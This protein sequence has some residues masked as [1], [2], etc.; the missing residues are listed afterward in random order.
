MT[1]TTSFILVPFILAFL[2]FV[3]RFYNREGA[4]SMTQPSFLLAVLTV[5]SAFTYLILG[6]TDTLPPYGTL[7]FAAIGV[8]L[9]G[10]AILR[11][12]MI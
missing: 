10:V 7:G 1:N 3:L 4:R 8:V 11:S 12:F 6:V 5:G 9:F 2:L